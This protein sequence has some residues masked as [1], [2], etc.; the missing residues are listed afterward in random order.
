[1]DWFFHRRRPAGRACAADYFLRRSRPAPA[2]R[3]L[4]RCRHTQHRVS[5]SSGGSGARDRRHGCRREAVSTTHELF[6]VRTPPDALALLLD[7]LLVQV[8][9]EEV[10][11]AESLDRVLARDVRAPSDLPTFRRSTMD[12]F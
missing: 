9:V 5:H 11:T 4:G 12:G 1:M 3:S 7:A 6:N 10:A 8:Q 2:S